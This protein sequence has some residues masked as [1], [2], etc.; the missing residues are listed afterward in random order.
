[1]STQPN[2]EQSFWHNDQLDLWNYVKTVCFN[3]MKEGWK[4]SQITT[5]IKINSSIKQR[6]C[7]LKY[8]KL[9]WYQFFF[10]ISRFKYLDQNSQKK[11]MCRN[12]KNKHTIINNRNTRTNELKFKVFCIDLGMKNTKNT[13]CFMYNSTRMPSILT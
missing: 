7:W 5:K 13:Q 10:H 2:V 12:R 1:M 9:L 3:C 8:Q 11:T 4:K 6:I